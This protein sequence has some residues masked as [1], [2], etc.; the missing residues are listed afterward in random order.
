MVHLATSL[1]LGSVLLSLL[2]SVAVAA[3]VRSA[4]GQPTAHRAGPSGGKRK[5]RGTQARNAASKVRL[6]T[7]ERSSL[8]L[9]ER[10]PE[11]YLPHTQLNQSSLVELISN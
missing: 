2:S 4:D 9:S 3:P 1:T 5:S 6:N 7:Q 10:S 8:R 11:P